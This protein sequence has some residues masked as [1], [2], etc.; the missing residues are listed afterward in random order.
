MEET[1]SYLDVFRLSLLECGVCIHLFYLS[2]P[3][4]LVVTESE[5]LYYY[6]YVHIHVFTKYI[7][8]I[9]NVLKT[10]ADIIMNGITYQKNQKHYYS[11]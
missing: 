5:D 11:L 1:E 3:G 7:M 8:I 2:W 4:Q 6:T 10:F 9:T